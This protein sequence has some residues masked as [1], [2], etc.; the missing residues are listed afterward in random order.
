MVRHD[1]Q[2]RHSPHRRPR[3]RQSLSFQPAFGDNRLA[4]RGKLAEILLQD[5]PEALHPPGLITVIARAM[6]RRVRHNHP[7]TRLGQRHRKVAV[8]QFRRGKAMIKDD[9]GQWLVQTLL[10]AGMQNFATAEVAHF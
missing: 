3:H 6:L 4:Q 1:T 10:R 8:N 5:R 2:G 9:T 7:E